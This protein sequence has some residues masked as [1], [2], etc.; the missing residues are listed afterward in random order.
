MARTPVTATREPEARRAVDQAAK[1]RPIGLALILLLAL[2][3]RLWRLDAQSLWY[4]EGWSIHLAT[5]PLSLALEQIASPGHTHP[6]G[7]YLLLMAW[8]RLLGDGIW[9]ARALSALLGTLTVWAIYR[10]GARLF[11]RITGLLAALLLAIAPGHIVYSQEMR[12]YALLLCCLTLLLERTY[13]AA[14]HGEEWPPTAWGLFALLE[15]VALYTHYLAFLALLGMALWL[16]AH[17]IRQARRD[18][19]RPLIAWLLSQGAV[20]LAFLPWLGIAMQRRSRAPSQPVAYAAMQGALYA[21]LLFGIMRAR[22]GYHPR[23]ALWL[24]IPT[25]LLL[26]R[27]LFLLWRGPI[28]GRAL[29]GLVALMWLGATGLAA[30][31]LGSDPYYN[32]DDARQTAAFVAEHM[33][34]ASLVLVDNDDWALRYYLKHRAVEDLYLGLELLAAY[35]TDPSA[36]RAL[37]ASLDRAQNRSYVALIK[38]YQGENDKRGLLSYLLEGRGTLVKREDLPGYSVYIYQLDAALPE[39]ERPKVQTW[40][41][42]V[43]ADFV[44]EGGLRLLSAT[45]ETFVPADETLAVALTWRVEQVTPH[46][47]KVALMLVNERGRVLARD[48]LLMR[49]GLGRG[50]QEW[51]LGRVTTTYHTL[52]VP[53]GLAPLEYGLELTVYHEGD[54]TGL[55]VLDEAGA[56]AGK[57]YPLASVV[58]DPALGRTGKTIAREA[59]GLHP[60]E[61]SPRVAPGLALAAFGLDADLEGS[62]WVCRTGDSLTA[63][64]EWQQAAAKSLPDYWPSLR[65]VRQGHILAS[66]ESAPVN[67]RYPT[68]WWQPGEVVLDWRELIIPADITSGPAELQ[69]RVRGEPPIPLAPLRVEAVP[70]LLE[71]PSPQV[72]TAL[73]IGRYELIG[74]DLGNSTISSGEEL[75]LTLYWRLLPS[76]GGR[77]ERSTVAYVVFAHLLNAEGR[78]IAQHDGP[79]AEGQRPTTGWIAGEYIADPHV[80]Q[81]LESDYRGAAVIEVG[82]YDPTS[83]QRLRTPTGDSRLLLPSSIMVW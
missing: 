38:W 61:G 68:S 7:Y 81:W 54:L 33:A 50:T 45:V 49:D 6:P 70:R 27:G 35:D 72:E 14:V 26:A 71:R 47:Y 75:P 31:A 44:G 2:G 58:L 22:P 69:I 60:L 20:L 83:G 11:G 19:A 57:R 51:P 42:N 24:L 1:L 25:A 8:V 74:Y 46:D 41:R 18:T 34:P 43:Y 67:D 23:Y 55:D 80:M 64:L 36:A 12:M 30:Y 9:A 40:S 28:V 10:A 63:L 32:R 59:L 29:G 62:E 16:G 37:E 48:D 5:E 82:L 79:P 21:L 39:G 52:S 53:A 73:Q 56:P 77:Y 17:L 78:L 4:D 13:D 15:I 65:L 66:E 3:V 76:S